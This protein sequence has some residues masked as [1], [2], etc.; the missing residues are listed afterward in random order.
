M[1]FAVTL[2]L[3][4]GTL[5]MTALDVGASSHA[6]QVEITS[7]TNEDP[8]DLGDEVDIRGT[9]QP[10]PTSIEDVN[11]T[12]NGEELN[13]QGTEDWQATWTPTE[14]GSYNIE[15]TAVDEDGTTGADQVTVRIQDQNPV[16]APGATSI[17]ILLAA[18]ATGGLWRDG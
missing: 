18:S 11:V 6:P 9:A 2:I 1:R 4:V 13:V 10:G 7:P 17:L 3:L 14:P 16:P 12:A 5:P 8:L 15:A